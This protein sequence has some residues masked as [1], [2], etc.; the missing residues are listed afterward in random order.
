MT[1]LIQLLL[2][3]RGAWG[4][5]LSVCLFALAW[6]AWRYFW[7]SW[8]V[9]RQL[10]AQ[11]RRPF[12]PFRRWSLVI[13][14]LGGLAL[15]TFSRPLVGIIEYV[16]TRWIDPVYIVADTSAWAQSVYEAEAARH[17]GASELALLKKRT[18][19]TAAKIGTTPL[20]IYEVALVECGMNP[21][22][23]RAD[24]IAAG[25]IQFTTLGLS[26]LGV[27]LEQVK[28]ACRRRD[29]GFIL[30]LTE[31]Y[32]LDRANG[33]PLPRSCDVYACVFAPGYIGAPD[34]QT[35][36]SRA[37]GAAYT[38]N[39]GLDG[40]RVINTLRGDLVVR[41]E[42]ACDGRITVNDLSLCLAAKKAR[43]LAQHGGRDGGIAGL[44]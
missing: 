28:D 4:Y 3:Q 40:Y 33:R 35:L 8:R 17:L 30:D 6:L 11:V 34:D 31:T 5:A 27:S 18:A 43:L 38:L 32:L 37:D 24:G 25:W 14:A 21:F 36:Y 15:Y 22:C 7:F 10:F 2:E 19:E 1:D 44:E 41:D 12:I 39:R 9:F 13:L 16:E 23:V 20:A 29:L 26:G 42:R